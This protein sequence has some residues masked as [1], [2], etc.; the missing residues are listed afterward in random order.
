MEPVGSV[1][2]ERRISFPRRTPGVPCWEQQA[3]DRTRGRTIRHTDTV[4]IR[5]PRRRRPH[6]VERRLRARVPNLAIEA[7]HELYEQGPGLRQRGRPLL[8]HDHVPPPTG[9]RTARLAVVPVILQAV[10][11]LRDRRHLDGHPRRA[12]DLL[13]QTREVVDARQAVADEEN[14][15]GSVSRHPAH[16]LRSA[17]AGAMRSAA[18]TGSQ[19]PPSAAAHKAAITA[20]N[21]AGSVGL[22]SNSSA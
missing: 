3:A 14:G 12:S 1:Q 11:R 9:D 17:S 20:A 6:H 4:E 7:A 8:E 19:H 2:R 16:S 10:I 15:E 21:V 18:R 22:I 5:R 13:H